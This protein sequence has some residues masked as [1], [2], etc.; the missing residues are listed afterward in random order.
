MEIKTIADLRKV[1]EHF[2]DQFTKQ[3]ETLGKRNPECPE[4]RIGAAR[5]NRE[6]ARNGVAAAERRHATLVRRAETE[7]SA[8]R[9]TVARLEG[10]LDGLNASAKGSGKPAR[11]AKPK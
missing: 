5:V 4:E 2:A 10:E 11:P 6:C 8:H 7:L 9:E 1:Q 3:L